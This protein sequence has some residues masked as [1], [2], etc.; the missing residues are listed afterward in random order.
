SGA[1]VFTD[2][3][4]FQLG[5]NRITSASHSSVVGTISGILAGILVILLAITAILFYKKRKAN[6]K[7][8]NNVAFENPSYLRGIEHVQI[9]TVT[10]DSNTPWRHETLQPPITSTQFNSPSSVASTISSKD[11]LKKKNG[12]GRRGVGATGTAAALDDSNS[13]VPMATE[14]NPSIYEELKLGQE[15]AG[16]K[17]LVS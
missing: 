16:F 10:P 9:P 7:A 2:P 14:V 17:K 4:K 3:I 1:S 8:A 12:V 5:D 6:E 15:G 11:S 13:I